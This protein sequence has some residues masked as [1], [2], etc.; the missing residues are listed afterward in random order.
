MAPHSFLFDREKILLRGRW[1]LAIGTTASAA[2]SCG[3]IAVRSS[4]YHGDGR[5]GAMAMADT[6][7]VSAVKDIL[8]K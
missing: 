1:C 2:F 6:V 5:Y 4:G 3:N 8:E 7:V